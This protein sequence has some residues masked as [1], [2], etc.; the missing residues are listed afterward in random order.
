[1]LACKMRGV[2]SDGSGPSRCP[3]NLSPASLIMGSRFFSNVFGPLLYCLSGLQVTVT[4]PGRNH[5]MLKLFPNRNMCFET[6]GG[7]MRILRSR[8]LW[9]SERY[10]HMGVLA[11]S[12]M[13]TDPNS[14]RQPSTK[15]KFSL[16]SGPLPFF[17]IYILNPDHISPTSTKINHRKWCAFHT[18]MG[19]EGSS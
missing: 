15:E 5:S 11:R 18:K 14:Y 2:F 19:K 4:S 1:M 8:T 7:R 9:P 6:P 12:F 10:R 17:V 16:T 13:I 3:E